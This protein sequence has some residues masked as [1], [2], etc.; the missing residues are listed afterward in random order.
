MH[1]GALKSYIMAPP[2]TVIKIVKYCFIWGGGG[3]LGGAKVLQM[4]MAPPPLSVIKIVKYCGVWGGG[5]KTLQK[6][7]PPPLTVIKIVKYCGVRGG[8]HWR[9]RSAK[10]LQN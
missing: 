7:V 2:L 3:S 5:A 10:I 4:I 1:W 6:I 9:G 8:G